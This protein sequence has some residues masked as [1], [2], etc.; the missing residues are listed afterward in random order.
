MVGKQSRLPGPKF[1]VSD[2]L[3]L[4]LGYRFFGADDP[5]HDDGVDEVELEYQNHS[6][7]LRIIFAL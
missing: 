5:V 4:D 7:L 1:A 2:N 3:S 6:V